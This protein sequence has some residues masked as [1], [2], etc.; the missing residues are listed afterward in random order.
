MT[1]KKI[2][3]DVENLTETEKKRKRLIESVQQLANA[4]YGKRAISRQLD[5]SRRT[6]EKYINGDPD[7]LC[8]SIKRSSLD[9]YTDLIVASIKNG[10]TVTA[11]MRILKE[12]GDTSSD[13]NIRQFIKSIIK[14]YGLE[15]QKYCSSPTREILKESK[16][17]KQRFTRKGIFNHLWMKIP[18]KEENWIKIL[19]EYPILKEVE[20]CIQSF[21]EMFDEKESH[22]LD[23]FIR[24]YKNSAIKELATFANGL[25]EDYDAVNGAVVSELSNG[26]VEGTN[27]K[28]KTVK[29][30]MYGRCRRELLEAK[31]ILRI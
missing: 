4:G 21:R 13:S 27:N 20:N 24:D 14:Q 19:K 17:G 8:R 1:V 29:R 15:Y 23:N 3:V 25:K 9:Q 31:M 28:V 2:A 6:V 16:T 10:K 5:I 7:I 30:S 22:Y 18:I 26:F 11:T 12:Q